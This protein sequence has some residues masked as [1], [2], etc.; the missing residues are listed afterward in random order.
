MKRPSKPT[1]QIMAGS[2][3]AEHKGWPLDPAYPENASHESGFKDDRD[4]Q[5]VLWQIYDCAVGGDRIPPWAGTAFRDLFEKVMRC[6]LTWTEAFGEVPAKKPD[7]RPKFHK[8]TLQKL[9]RDI[10]RVGEAVL[11]Y[12][13]PKDEKMWSVLRKGLG[14]NRREL[15]DRWRR[16]KLAHKS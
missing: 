7:G 12:K 4:N 13:G 8:P 11:S 5:R 9:G 6:E 2:V 14:L 3:R 10:I 15:K 16:Y 1:G